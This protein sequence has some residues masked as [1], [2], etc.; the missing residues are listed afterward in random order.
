MLNSRKRSRT[1]Y[2]RNLNNDRDRLLAL[3][4]EYNSESEESIDEDEICIEPSQCMERDSHSDDACSLPSD[5]H[6][7]V[8]S[9]FSYE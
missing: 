7:D 4:Q 1:S 5:V 9:D 3:V 2:F 6:L 8:E